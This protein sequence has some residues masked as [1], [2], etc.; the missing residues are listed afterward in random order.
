MNGTI[1]CA[2][3]DSGETQAAVKVARR[4]AERF[5]LRLLLVSVAPDSRAQGTNGQEG[6]PARE[7]PDRTKRRPERLVAADWLTREEQRAAIGHP[8][9]AVATIA[10]EEAADLIVLGARRGRLGRTLRSPL[11]A[12]LAETA[13]CPVLV[14]PAAPAETPRAGTRGPSLAERRRR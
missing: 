6:E 4:L 11:A 7:A 13:S 5:D 9:E 8:A 14:V 10:A 2:L 1:V 12:D 3:D